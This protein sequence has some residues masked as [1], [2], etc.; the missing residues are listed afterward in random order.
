MCELFGGGKIAAPHQNDAN[1]KRARDD[2]ARS[3]NRPCPR[4]L[5]HRERVV[6]P[7]TQLASSATATAMIVPMNAAVIST[8]GLVKRLPE[9]N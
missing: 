4:F 6:E 5:L 3:S 1:K 2:S 8:P 9:F 7:P